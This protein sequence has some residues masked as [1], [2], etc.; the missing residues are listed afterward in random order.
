ME[1]VG[2]G[3]KVNGEKERCG[4]SLNGFSFQVSG[5]SIGFGREHLVKSNPKSGT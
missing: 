2:V 3:S 5:V 4:C 1:W